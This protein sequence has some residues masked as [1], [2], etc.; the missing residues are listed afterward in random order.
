M[1]SGIITSRGT[2]KSIQDTGVERR[3][4]LS[5]P[6]Q[7]WRR[8]STG[9]SLSVSGICLTVLTRHSSS[10]DFE[11]MPQ[12]LHL[13][14]AEGWKEGQI[15]N[16]EPALRLGDE[17]GG[18]LVYGHIDGM[19]EL[20]RRSLDGS[21]TIMTFKVSTDIAKMLLP[22]ASV[23]IDGVS[24]TVVD[25]DGDQFT[26]SLLPFTLTTTTLSS[27]T[28]HDRVNIELDMMAKYAQQLVQAH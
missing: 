25:V 17:I 8:L 13:T 11:L 4:K 15:V 3:L 28:L 5:V 27:L 22:R 19:G 10:I 18:H 12:T 7:I 23:A 21:A 14:T 6:L 9:S 1:F 24:L 26:V 2:I 20:V 16:I